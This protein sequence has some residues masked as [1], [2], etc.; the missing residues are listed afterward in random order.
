MVSY[1][2]LAASK[3]ETSWANELDQIALDLQAL[4]GNLVRLHDRQAANLQTLIA[5]YPQLAD[6]LA[7]PPGPLPGTGGDYPAAV[8]RLNADAQALV[9]AV[10][11]Y[12]DV[13]DLAGRSQFA[14]AQQRLE[15]DLAT[16]RRLTSPAA[17]AGS[18][19]QISALAESLPVLG[20]TL[21]SDRDEEQLSF[22]RF[23][24]EVFQ[25]EQEVIARQIQPLEDRR[26]GDAQRELQRA[27]FSAIAT[28][29]LVPIALTLLAGLGAVRL[30]R[31]MDQNISAVLAG[32]DRVAAGDL[33]QPV[34][35]TT[36]DELKR[37]ADA[38]N[39]MMADLAAR[40]Q[41]LRTLMETLAHVQDEERRLVGLD[42]HDGLTQLIISANMHL[43]ALRSRL[44]ATADA[45]VAHEL[46]ETQALLKGAIEEARRVIAEL[47]PTVVED[48]GL[49]E[50]LRRYVL[51]V[52]E[53]EGWQ[54]ETQIELAGAVLSRPAEAAIF[55]IAQEALSN[56]RKHSGTRTIYV[57]LR[58][59]GHELLLDVRDWG[60]GF[61][62]AA[63]ADDAQQIGLIGMKERAAML[64]GVGEIV[65]EP[66]QGTRVLVRLPTT[67]IQ[68]SADEGS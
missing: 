51:E 15:Q 45:G 24:A 40:E 19:P 58:S 21:M 38:F 5:T 50:G 29:L 27:I 62:P 30:A 55:R 57:A 34:R 12:L 43:N 54:C 31:R 2:S 68:G 46:A 17:D 13:P 7:Q 22:T 35:V 53:A 47:R 61:D 42:L 28:S 65:S 16:F 3:D 60:S 52:A 37:L 33:T 9:L 4:G 39:E 6:L 44:S 26:L 48:F 32:A 10:T 23:A 18:E 49:A 8:D 56:A 14:R 59:D 11:A 25:G 67:A 64:G 63:L 66:G 36:T 20:G 41:G 1:R